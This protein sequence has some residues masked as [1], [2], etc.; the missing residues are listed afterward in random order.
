VNVSGRVRTAFSP[1]TH[2]CTLREKAEGPVGEEEG[3]GARE[4]VPPH[5]GKI[6]VQ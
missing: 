6:S 4:M 2:A 1:R 3:E 5:V